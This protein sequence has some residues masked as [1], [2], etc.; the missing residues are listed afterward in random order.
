MSRSSRLPF[1]FSFRIY[2]PVLCSAPLRG[3]W[4]FGRT[5]G[6]P[7]KISSNRKKSWQRKEQK[8]SDEKW[9]HLF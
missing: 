3:F 1:I 7:G 2:V 6:E 4:R 8:K 9:D 5:V